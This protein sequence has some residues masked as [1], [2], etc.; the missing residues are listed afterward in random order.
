M[1]L[2]DDPGLLEL[3]T[4]GEPLGAGIRVRPQEKVN[5]AVPA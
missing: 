1:A 2:T 5:R 3:L 4:D